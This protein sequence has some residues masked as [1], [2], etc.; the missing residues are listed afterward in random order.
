MFI[1]CEVLLFKI[2]ADI[3]IIEQAWELN[4]SVT[5]AIRFGQLEREVNVQV[6]KI[7]TVVGR[8]NGIIN[9][10]AKIPKH[11]NTYYNI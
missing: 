11:S 3:E 1:N 7:N 9:T 8:M 6:L 2:V 4:Y 5:L 10:S